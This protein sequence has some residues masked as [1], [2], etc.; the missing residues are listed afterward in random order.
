MK[1]RE[2]MREKKKDRESQVERVE[3]AKIESGKRV[4]DGETWRERV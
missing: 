3:R 1:K 4:K 2:R